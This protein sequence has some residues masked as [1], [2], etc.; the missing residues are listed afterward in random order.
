MREKESI[1]F[2]AEKDIFFLQGIPG[3]RFLE[4]TAS[5]LPYLAAY[6]ATV[7]F[8]RQLCGAPERA[9]GKRAAPRG[10]PSP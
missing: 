10:L 7:P 6:A 2:K 4:K 8:Y 1:L 5:K 9:R 3:L